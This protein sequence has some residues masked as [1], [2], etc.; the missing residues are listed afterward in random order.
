MKSPL[1]WG[2]KI[3][4]LMGL[5]DWTINC[6]AIKTG[7]KEKFGWFWNLRC[8][9][10][11]KNNWMEFFYLLPKKKWQNFARQ[12]KESKADYDNTNKMAELISNQ[13]F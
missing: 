13:Q 6:V 12:E 7:T 11:H 10:K 9:L 4:F 1:E 2:V 3:F 8:F 5:F